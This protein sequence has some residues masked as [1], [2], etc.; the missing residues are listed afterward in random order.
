M[1]RIHHRRATAG[2]A[3]GFMTIIALFGVLAALTIGLGPTETASGSLAHVQI[4][5]G[6]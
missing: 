3:S 5:A 1:S 2:F 6:R 4:G